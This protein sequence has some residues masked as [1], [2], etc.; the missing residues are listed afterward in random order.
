MENISFSDI[1]GIIG[2]LLLILA[3]YLVQKNKELAEKSIYYLLNL[4]GS[5]FI[6]F[7]LIFKWNLSAFLIEFFWILISISGLYKTLKKR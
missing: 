3:Y 7:S 4:T 6:I 2:S 1:I 5:L